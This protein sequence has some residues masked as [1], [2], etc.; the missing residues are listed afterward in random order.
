MNCFVM[1]IL[2]VRNSLHVY[3]I[4]H[5]INKLQIEMF[6]GLTGRS[7]LYLD[8]CWTFV[9]GSLRQTLRLTVASVH[10]LSLIKLLFYVLRVLCDLSFNLDF[11][12]CWCE[13][14]SYIPSHLSTA[15]FSAASQF[16]SVF[17]SYKDFFFLP[18]FVCVRLLVEI[19]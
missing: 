3:I 12:T 11:L 6:V 2:G 5:T 17:L 7:S 1:H 19:H 18:L 8:R 4:D 10:L 14:S 16:D 13:I 15:M 9:L